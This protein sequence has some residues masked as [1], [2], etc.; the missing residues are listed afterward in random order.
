MPSSEE[1]FPRRLAPPID[2]REIG[3]AAIPQFP[4]NAEYILLP[5]PPTPPPSPTRA[6]SQ[7]ARS[8]EWRH[9]VTLHILVGKISISFFLFYYE[10]MLS[11]VVLCG[12]NSNYFF[13]FVLIQ[14]CIRDTNEIVLIVVF[15]GKKYVTIYLYLYIYICVKILKLYWPSNRW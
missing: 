7:W 9:A 5:Q 3:D 10:C 8:L 1:N 2:K 6:N 14:T 15:L 11:L 4:G 12:R 13:S